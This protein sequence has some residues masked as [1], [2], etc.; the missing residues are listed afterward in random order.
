[1]L[2]LN[3]GGEFVPTELVS[4]P[5]RWFSNSA[6]VADV[7]G[8]GHLDVVVANYFPDGA[9][10][11]E[12]QGD[13]VESMQYSMSRAFNG[14]GKHVLLRRPGVA[15]GFVDWSDLFDEETA[16]GWTLA[17]GACNLDGDLLPELYM[18]NDFG[19]DR[20]LHNRSTPGAPRFARVE[21]ASSFSTPSSK[22][23]GRDSFKGMGVDF[24]DLN[25]DGRFDIVVSNIATEWGLLESH[26]AFV[27]TGNPG[28]MARGVAPYVDQSEPLGLSRSSWGWDLKLADFDN[29]GELELVQSTGFVHGDVDRWPELQELAMGNDGLLPHPQSWPRVRPGDDLSGHERPRFF[30]RTGGRFVDVGRE[31]GIDWPEVSRGIAIADVDGDGNLDFA[32]AGQWEPTVFYRNECRDCGSFLGLHLRLPLD[33]AFDHVDVRDGHPDPARPSRDAIGATVTVT[34]PD[35][36]RLVRQVD[37]GSGHSGKRSSDVHFGLGAVS[38]STPLVVTVRYRDMT[39][40]PRDV[41]TSLGPGWHTV[42]LRTGK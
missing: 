25:G 27:S 34:L 41:T 2:F 16:H 22:V 5:A 35:G 9:H 12:P 6:A 20:M 15:G 23:L 3:R 42:Y 17:V 18:A 13:G 31:L 7:D 38:A 29:D 37:G 32:V 30:A 10:V 26:F 8:D 24:G 11:L 28:A 1:M 40:A 21:A 19:P 39:G 4:T 14:G 36:R 33:G